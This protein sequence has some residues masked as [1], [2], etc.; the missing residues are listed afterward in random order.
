MNFMTHFLRQIAS[1][2]DFRAQAHVIARTGQL[3]IYILSKQLSKFSVALCKWQNV[4]RNFYLPI[5]EV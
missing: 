3:T 4:G 2:T 5:I 1:L